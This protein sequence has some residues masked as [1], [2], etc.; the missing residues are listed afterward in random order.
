MAKK[1][2]APID[3]H[4]TR[5]G[6]VLAEI[7]LEALAEIGEDLVQQVM[8]NW[9]SL[10]ASQKLKATK[11]ISPKG[12]VAY[13]Q[14][15]LDTLAVIA[16]DA[17]AQARKEVPAKQNV[18]LK[19]G[20][21]SRFEGPDSVVDRV[22]SD[23]DAQ[24]FCLGEF[25]RLPPK[26]QRKI[27][28]QMALLVGKQLSDLQ[29]VITFAYAQAEEETDSEEQI[30][31]DLRDSAV[32][33]LDGTAISAGATLN[34]ATTIN[35][36]RNAFFYDEDVLSGIEAMEFVNGDPVCP[37]C[38][39][40]AGTIFDKNDPAADR[41]GVPLHWNCRCS[42]QPIPI[43]ELGNR[44]ITKLAPS[45]KALEKYVLFAEGDFELHN[46]D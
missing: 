33:W 1:K 40:L 43:G 18:R 13:R 3:K 41:Y 2:K 46:H 36:A 27:K 26:V 28:S 6:K 30:L 22:G 12:V 38:T 17:I 35:S 42:I 11:D 24:S 8:R 44:E 10:S 29:S 5:G 4:I 34:A 39:D 20:N 31:Q 19:E 25:D 37:L 15:V 21:V 23:G 14:A 45:S 32:G 16:A 7:S 9:R